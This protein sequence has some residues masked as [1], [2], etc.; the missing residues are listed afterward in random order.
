MSD[1]KQLTDYV[2]SLVEEDALV[3]INEKQTVKSESEWLKGVLKDVRKNKKHALLAE[4]D[5][6]VIS[7]VELRKD[8]WRSSHVASVAIAVKKKYRRLGVATIMMKTILDIGKK[9]KDIKV[10]FLD[11][12]EANKPA[13]KLYKKLGF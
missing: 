10:M 8:R 6:E 5:D 4:C 3:H 11:V 9:D 7:V 1:I 13:L 2:N 12:Y